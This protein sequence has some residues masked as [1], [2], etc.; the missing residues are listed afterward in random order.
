LDNIKIYQEVIL[1]GELNGRVGSKVDNRVVRPFG[2][3]IMVIHHKTW[4]L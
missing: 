4:Q 2:E 1:E 3:E